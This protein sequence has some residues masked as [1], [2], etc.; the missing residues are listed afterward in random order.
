MSIEI[1]KLHFELAPN[2][3]PSIERG[4]LKLERL[5]RKLSASAFPPAMAEQ[6]Y[7]HWQKGN[8]HYFQ[9]GI[10]ANR[11]VAMLLHHPELSDD[12][13]LKQAVSRASVDYPSRTMVIGLMAWCKLNWQRAN[14]SDF[15]AALHHSSMAL[16]LVA[17]GESKLQHGIGPL[18][19]FL[20][21]P[22]G[23]DA[24][25]E[26]I[27]QSEGAWDAF[28]QE[29][30]VT[31][32]EV[33][34]E[35]FERVAKKYVYTLMENCPTSEFNELIVGTIQSLCGARLEGVLLTL[36]SSVVNRV[37]E[38]GVDH[39]GIMQLAIRK[40]GDPTSPAWLAV[41]DLSELERKQVSAAANILDQWVNELFLDRFWQLITDRGRQKYWRRRKK[42]MRDV[43]LAISESYF[44]QLPSELRAGE[45]RKRLHRTSTNALLIFKI[46]EKSF[47]EYGERASGPLQVVNSSSMNGIRL[48]DS[49]SRSSRSAPMAST[50]DPLSLKFYSSTKQHLIR[51]GSEFSEEG[52]LDHM[53][54]WEQRLDQWFAWVNRKKR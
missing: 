48:A 52:K 13:Q 30:G 18:L 8:H 46:G 50:I 26:R 49:L 12:E 2:V 11:L 36:I 53:T 19:P 37:E 20:Q 22:D 43:R 15:Q 47:I 7:E 3:G 38:L 29:I 16:N 40:I 41:D 51:Y 33:S 9:R 10:G 14:R 4:R 34:G 42:S 21:M 17:D 35:F 44:G 1:P 39:E 25:A 31:E 6:A 45:Y 23:H 5:E 54:N 28:I 24:F 27:G 32:F